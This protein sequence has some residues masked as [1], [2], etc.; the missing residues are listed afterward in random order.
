MNSATTAEA[1]ARNIEATDSVVAIQYPT[2]SQKVIQSVQEKGL[3]SSK[4]NLVS[5]F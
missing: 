2:V 4:L 3:V 5:N 1:A